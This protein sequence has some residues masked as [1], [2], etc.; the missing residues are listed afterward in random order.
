MRSGSD[1]FGKIVDSRSLVFSLC[2]WNLSELQLLE[3]SE[4]MYQ[5]MNDLFADNCILNWK[6]NKKNLKSVNQIKNN[7]IKNGNFGVELTADVISK[8][9]F[10]KKSQNLYDMKLKYGLSYLVRKCSL[11]ESYDYRKSCIEEQHHMDKHS[12]SKDVLLKL[13]ALE[14]HVYLNVIQKHDV[15]CFISC[16]DYDDGKCSGVIEFLGNVYSLDEKVNNVAI[17][18]YNFSVYASHTFENINA[19]ITTT[20]WANEHNNYFSE[21]N[22]PDEYYVDILSGV[23]SETGED[24]DDAAEVAYIKELGWANVISPMHAA[25]L[26]DNIEK[27]GTENVEVKVLENRAVSVKIKDGID[28]LQLSDLKTV[29]RIMYPCL[30]PGHTEFPLNYKFRSMWEYVPVLDDEITVTDNSVIFRINRE[31]DLEYLKK[32]IDL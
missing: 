8:T 18:L 28:R 26:G 17:K 21:L 23:F 30:Y 12:N 24:Y 2:F 19:Y 7:S 11:N 9:V 4:T 15:Y 32:F 10:D 27:E 16:D 20:V 25:L 22:L 31:P 6:M 5:I 13:F 29:K 1:V 3:L 14:N